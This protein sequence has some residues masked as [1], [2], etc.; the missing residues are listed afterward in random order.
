V[1]LRSAW[2]S[3]LWL[4]SAGAQAQGECPA[5]GPGMQ[6]LREGNVQVQWR[7][8]PAIAVG[9]PFALDIHVCPS[10]AELLRVDATMPE[11]RHG[12]NY[13]PS[14]T[15]LGAGRWRVEGLLWHMSGRW[16]LRLDLKHAGQ[17]LRLRQS[18]TL[19]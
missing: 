5:P 15:P 12:M 8:Q 11:H 7:A 16:E 18:V 17:D 19:P 4:A 6:V 2:A 9:Q 14:L 3:L 10:T 13:R 1:I